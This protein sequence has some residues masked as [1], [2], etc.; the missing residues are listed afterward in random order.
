ML[1]PSRREPV[2]PAAVS[3]DFDEA[4]EIMES[5]AE[6]RARELGPGDLLTLRALG[7][8]M[9]IR[10]EQSRWSDVRK[11]GARIL[12][13]APP[14]HPGRESVKKV[15]DE[16]DDTDRPGAILTCV[17]FPKSDCEIDA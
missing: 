15:L 7:L 9:Q 3:I 11:I 14:D 8:L 6:V 1:T 12:E 16:L 13:H 4:G 2:G 10:H 17:A 5:V